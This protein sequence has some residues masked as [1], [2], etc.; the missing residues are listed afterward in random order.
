MLWDITPFRRIRWHFL[1][2][3][4]LRSGSYPTLSCTD[5]GLQYRAI[6]PTRF[7]S[8]DFNTSTGSTSSELACG[9]VRKETGIFHYN[10]HRFHL[11]NTPFVDTYGDQRGYIVEIRPGED[12]KSHITDPPLDQALIVLPQAPTRLVREYER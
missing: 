3:K 6:S 2:L 11:Y 12:L 7:Y 8:F 9:Q 5:P 4:H 10:K 1:E